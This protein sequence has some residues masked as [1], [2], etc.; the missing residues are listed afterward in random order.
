MGERK[1]TVTFGGKDVEATEVSF[2]P[3]REPWSEYLLDD[4]SVVKLKS[5]VTE[6]VRLD[7]QYD[8]VGDPIYVVKSTQ[9]VAVSANDKLRRRGKPS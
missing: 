6:V 8:Q 2:Q 4:G 1:K 7:D 5:V 3:S 9:I